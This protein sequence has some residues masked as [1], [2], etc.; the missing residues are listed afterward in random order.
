[1][2]LFRENIVKSK[3]RAPE[4]TSTCTLTLMRGLPPP[5]PQMVLTHTAFLEEGE[6]FTK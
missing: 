4:V 3:P 5:P 6:G 2:T 1:M